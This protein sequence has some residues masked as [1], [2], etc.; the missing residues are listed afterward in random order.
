[1]PVL[2]AEAP[3]S[4]GVSFNHIACGDSSVD[5]LWESGTGGFASFGDYVRTASL[6][7]A[8]R[9]N[10]LAVGRSEQ[11]KYDTWAF[12]SRAYRGW[13]AERDYPAVARAVS[14]PDG[15]YEL[16]DADG[17]AL[18]PPGYVR[19][20]FDKARFRD[21]PMSRC[22]TVIAPSNAGVLPMVA[23]TSR[24][25]GS[26]WG[27]I[28]SYWEGEAQQ[29]QAKHPTLMDA[30]YRLKKLTALVPASEE[31]IQ[32]SSLL[33][34]FITE[35][36]SKEFQFK[37]NDALINGNGVGQ[38]LGIVDAPGTITIAKDTGQASGTLS[39]SNI[40]N[41]W[42]QSH[43]A[44]RA[45]MVWYTQ[46]DIDPDTLGL[47]VSPTTAWG[48]PQECPH[49]KGRPFLPLENCQPIGTTGDV[50]LAD[51]SQVLLLLGGMRKSLS[52]HFK[53][54]YF[55][56][57]FKFVWRCDAQPLW[58]IPLTPPHSTIQKSAYLV[59]AKR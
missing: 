28:L 6:V 32:D 8:G 27:G 3:H 26:R 22:K 46:E 4:N 34:P 52:M 58:Q 54:D 15:M 33:D 14:T 45:N 57:Y 40:Q 30:Q 49:V 53:F 20:V 29:L 36:V 9:I 21:T 13:L 56:G 37:T 42:T 5:R 23:E 47:P 7:H 50:V 12:A 43:G 44:S 1:M 16:T 48:G 18:I 39:A 59:L 10:K 35:V 41:M 19:E 25:D 2:T 55:E 11:E 51:W 24:V 38:I 17:G 31:L